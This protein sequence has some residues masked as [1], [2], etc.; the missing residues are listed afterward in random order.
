MSNG[1]M[2]IRGRGDMSVGIGEEMAKTIREKAY[3]KDFAGNS[4]RYF[5]LEEGFLS[6]SCG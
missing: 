6:C 4:G 1:W 5:D 3:G 2:G